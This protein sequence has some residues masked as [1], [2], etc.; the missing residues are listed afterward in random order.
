MTNIVIGKDVE[1]GQPV[2]I[3]PAARSQHLYLIGTTGTGKT[4]LLQNIVL[5]DMKAG[6]GLCFIDPHGKGVDELLTMVPEEREADVILW[7]SLDGERPFGLNLFECQD[8]RDAVQRDRVADMFVKTFKRIFPEAFAS[9]PRMEELMRNMAHTFIENPGSTLAE[10]TQFLMDDR[11]RRQFL[12][13][14][15]NP[16]IRE[17]YW[18]YFNLRTLREQHEVISSSLNKLGRFLANTLI[19]NIFGQS[20]SSL[21]LAD[22][23]NQRKIILVRIPVNELSEETAELLGSIL[24]GRILEAAFSRGTRG[25]LPPFHLI[26]DEFHRFVSSAFPTLLAEARKFKIDVVIANQWLS[27]LEKGEDKAARDAAMSVRNKIIFSVQPLD[28]ALLAKGFD[29]TPPPAEK[30]LEMVTQ[31]AIHTWEEREDYWTSK[32][33]EARFQELGI[34][35][36]KLLVR[37]DVFQAGSKVQPN[38]PEFLDP[39]AAAE[40]KDV[41]REILGLGVYKIDELLRLKWKDEKEWKKVRKELRK[42]N[43]KRKSFYF[44]VSLPCLAEE[45]IERWVE[46]IKSEENRP[47]KAERPHP[48]HISMP[49]GEE[50]QRIGREVLAEVQQMLKPLKEKANPRWFTYY[51]PYQETERPHHWVEYRDPNVGRLITLDCIG[52]WESGRFFNEGYTWFKDKISEFL[53]Q[54]GAHRKKRRELW[55]TCHAVRIVKKQRYLGYDVPEEHSGPGL[56]STQKY[57]W[58]DGPPRL[59]SDV[60]AEIANGLS[61]LPEHTARCK[62][63]LNGRPH[64]YTITTHPPPAVAPDGEARAE[65]IRDRSRQLYGRPRA[66]VEQGIADRLQL[67]PTKPPAQDESEDDEPEDD[68]YYG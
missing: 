61:N 36:G 54:I 4:T 64:E 6:D 17:R 11:Y 30:R 8:P 39:L 49:D 63:L 22:L 38:D 33:A 53:N 51:D 24:V 15:T 66:A 48:D 56:G 43:G 32:E 10:T 41:C 47:K 23:M 55:D 60:E 34:L 3:D 42:L 1:S 26:V 27:Q 65:R 45:R 25:D 40:A 2:P 57:Q 21:D 18:P 12:P 67:T 68:P 16:E 9:G 29:T 62:L 50:K 44:P 59:R 52:V 37:L 20:T 5:A 14:V 19:R 58:V 7:D 28:A 31:P 46:E 13:Q 35:L